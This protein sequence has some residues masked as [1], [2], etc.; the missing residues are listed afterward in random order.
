MAA[1]FAVAPVADW[2]PS[3][4]S[5]DE[6]PVSSFKLPTQ[7]NSVKDAI[8]DFRRFVEHEAWERAFKSLETITSK[9]TDG[10][11]ERPDRV[12]VPSRL[13]VR[14]LLA[15]MPPAGKSA[16]RVFYD[17]E[18]MALW[19]KATGAAE[20]DNLTQIVDNHLVSSLGD[21]AADRLG[22]LY[23]ERGELHRAISAWQTV[24]TYRPDSE[25]SKAQLLIKVAT[26]STL[27]GRGSELG[28]IRRAIDQRYADETVVVGGRRVK[29][30]EEIARLAASVQSVEVVAEA[31]VLDDFQLPTS[32]EVLWQFRYRTKADPNNPANAGQPFPV[33]NVYGQMRAND[34]PIP[35]ATDGKRVYLNT[36][37]VE[38]AFDL[39]TG[40]MLWGTGRMHE[41]NFQQ[42]RQGVLPERYSIMVAGDRTWSV[43]RD[44]KQ[45]SRQ[46]PM[47]S[48]VARDAATGKELF[49]SRR[50]MSTW[51]IVGV[52][53]LARDPGSSQAT[54]AG[55]VTS[56]AGQDGAP[57]T[58]PLT[59]GDVIYIG[60]SRT[61][62]SAE[63]SVLV[64]D[65]MTGKLKKNV[66]LGTHAVDPNQVYYDQ[67]SQPSFTMVRDRLYVDT[68]AGALVALRPETATIEWGIL[69]ESPPPSTGYNSYGYRP[70]RFGT[71]GPMAAG[72][73][74]FAKGMRSPRIVAVE[75]S[76]RT[77]AWR[78][79]IDVTAVL[80]GAD[81]EYLYTGGEELAAY[82]LKTQELAWS[83]RLPSSAAWSVPVL[84][85]TRLYQFTSRGIYEVDKRTGRVV[86]LFRGADLDA[87]GGSLFVTPTALVTVSNVAITV[88]LL[89]DS[90]NN[91]DADR[92]AHS[93]KP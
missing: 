17:A 73:L 55:R 70:P 1:Q 7:T 78:R 65:A 44:P 77:I 6:K 23:F 31:E 51:S 74:L 60:A 16:Y 18:A 9:A 32:D 52:P 91:P 25:T 46:P 58:K 39:A 86:R 92:E 87:L 62:K 85:K 11:V 35:A 24:L 5:G 64:I 56:S 28:D 13:L 22:D 81:D 61:N 21:R 69:Y 66:M 71:S 49:S 41:L 34:F 68:H 48:L 72:G 29:A 36:F 3:S 45:M 59:A 27:A 53:Y 63:L 50:T 26:A 19:E 12:L 30:G 33:R 38:M 83:T 43:T 67:A 15:S 37:G 20:V 84:T 40:K 93:S 47:F 82:D 80:V 79:P 4:K 89:N 88:Y 2:T 75:Q 42:S 76:G 57:S 14:S 8:E 90:A 54:S 10:F